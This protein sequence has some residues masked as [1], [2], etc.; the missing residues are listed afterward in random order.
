MSDAN[1]RDVGRPGIPVDSSGG[2][3][4]D[5]TKNVLDLVDA[6]V[7]R[8]DDLRAIIA[9]SVEFEHVSLKEYVVDLLLAYDKRYEQRH[10]ASQRALEAA[11]VAQ[12][13]AVKEA[14]VAQNAA[15]N[16][17][18]TSAERAVLKAENASEKRFEGVNEFRAQLGDQQRTLMPR[19][20][21]ESQNNA[22]KDRLG[23]LESFRTEA[24]SRGTGAKEGYGW[25][26]GLVG[27]ILA[28]ITIISVAVALLAR[29]KP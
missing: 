24:L 5:P 7:K 8:Q 18:L 26:I 20:E 16:A 15:I 25:A 12:K 11:L 17:A 1:V 27:V 22:L 28:L 19:A 3:T 23:I 14:F 2:P 9:R 29:L 13:E 4:I 10:E 21:Y 6:S